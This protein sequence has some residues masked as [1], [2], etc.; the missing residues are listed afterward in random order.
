MSLLRYTLFA[1]RP[2]L[3]DK[4]DNYFIMNYILTAQD[5]SVKLE[6]IQ[7][8]ERPGAVQEAPQGGEHPVLQGLKA[9]AE[10]QS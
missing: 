1:P 8:D 2:G 3:E 9:V 5:G 4:P 7:E 6:I 10:Y